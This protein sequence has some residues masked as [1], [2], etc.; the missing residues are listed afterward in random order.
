MWIAY[1]NRGLGTFVVPYFY[2]SRGLQFGP[3][4][5]ELSLCSF[6]VQ[7][8]GL[9]MQNMTLKNAIRIGK[10][11]GS[12]LEV[13]NGD[14]PGLICRQHLRLRVEINT[15]RPLMPGFYISRPGKDPLW[16]QFRYERLADY[17]TLCGLIGHCKFICPDP[18]CKPPANYS[19]SLLAASSSYPRIIPPAN[20]EHAAA[21]SSAY[22][23]TNLSRS[24]V[25]T[26]HG[27]EPT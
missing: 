3:D 17:C 12:L 6:W 14:S 25:S 13:E 20:L 19:I 27:A 15:R 24:S 5:V 11:I 9:P 2:S 7:V 10:S 16:I 1:Y 21:G 22:L 18:P 8:H 4:E 26:S 23:P